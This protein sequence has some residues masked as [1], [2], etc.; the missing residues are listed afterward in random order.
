MQVKHEQELRFLDVENL[1]HG[2]PCSPVLHKR[3]YAM[4]SPDMPARS[5]VRWIICPL[6]PLISLSISE[7]L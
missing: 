4:G 5:T 2:P 3:A 1:S 7:R 6:Q